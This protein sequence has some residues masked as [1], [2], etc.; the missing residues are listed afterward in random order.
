[1]RYL[2]TVFTIF[3]KDIVLE[4]KTREI[5]NSAL[6]FAVLLVLSFSFIMEP[7]SDTEKHIAG[8]IFWMSVTFAGILG[9][10]KTMLNEV[11]G[12]NFEALMLC[13]VD[14]S[15][16]FFG[17]VLSSFVYLL[18]LEAVLI[19]LFI[20]FYNINIVSHKL[21]IIVLLLST[22]GYACAG[23]LFAIISVK[24]KTREL[25]MPL[26]MLPVMIP[27]IISS[28]LATNVFIFEY[29]ITA[30]YSWI[31]LTAVFDIIFTAVTFALFSHIIEE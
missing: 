19:P 27:V 22:Y 14:R 10:S 29:D 23:T 13:P 26:L 8:G 11:Q 30:C 20:I 21:M 3:K 2:K 17:K 12:G 1:M 15:A 7:G 28:I 24:T 5:V 25:M 4:I 6:V 18:I 9:L 16:V 31:K